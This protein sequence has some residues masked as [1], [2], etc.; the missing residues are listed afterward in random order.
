M[1]MQTNK[2]LYFML[3]TYANQEA[4]KSIIRPCNFIYVIIRCQFTCC[5]HH[6]P[7]VNLEN[8]ICSMLCFSLQFRMYETIETAFTERIRCMISRYRIKWDLSEIYFLF[9]SLIFSTA[10]YSINIFPTS[11]TPLIQQRSISST[12]ICTRLEMQSVQ[13]AKKKMEREINVRDIQYTNSL[14]I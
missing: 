2:F 9:L 1:I 12:F 13:K 10:I 7:S 3:Q 11:S 4:I 14:F 6:F 5:Y 8:P